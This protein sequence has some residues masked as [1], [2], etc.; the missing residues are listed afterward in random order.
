[1]SLPFVVGL[2]IGEADWR[3]GPRAERLPPVG[4][5]RRTPPDPPPALARCALSDE[6]R[7][8]LH[9]VLG[10]RVRAARVELGVTQAQLAAALGRTQS[11]VAEVESGRTVCQPYVI[12]A[13]AA[14]SGR[15]A[16]WFFGEPDKRG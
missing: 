4:R 14:A 12:A 11:W 2:R 7:D 9:R 3:R 6:Q 8:A 5:R 1:M 16:G 13:L 10:E 15:S